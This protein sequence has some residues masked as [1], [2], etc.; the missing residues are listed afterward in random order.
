MVIR[1]T[2]VD[3]D[4]DAR[5][6]MLARTVVLEHRWSLRRRN[7]DLPQFSPKVQNVSE[8]SDASYAIASFLLGHHP[9]TN[10]RFLSAT[11]RV[12]LET[13][14]TKSGGAEVV[15]NTL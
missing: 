11:R 14:E 6:E 8:I 3:A 9:L 4:G 1:V 13:F 12:R 15:Q 2:A 5:G 10:G 7:L